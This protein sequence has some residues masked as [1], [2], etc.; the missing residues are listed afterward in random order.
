MIYFIKQGA[1]FI[2]IGYAADPAARLKTLQTGSPF[3]LKLVGTIPGSYQTEKTLHE[4]FDSLKTR[5]NNEWFR[6]DGKLKAC[7]KA[8]TDVGRKHSD[9][10]TVKQ[11]LE[12]GMHL[13]VRQKAN[14]KKKK[15][16]DGWLD[17]QLRHEQR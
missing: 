7:I 16:N 4:E 1:K 12:N 11:F 17:A 9:V 2:K 3:K 13:Q 14:R 10:K 8:H 6:F 15:G 5:A